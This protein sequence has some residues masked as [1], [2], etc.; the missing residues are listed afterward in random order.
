[1]LERRR[2]FQYPLPTGKPP[3]RPWPTGRPERRPLRSNLIALVASAFLMLVVLLSL[4]APLVAPDDPMAVDVAVQLQPP[5]LA[6]LAGT[7]LFGRD[8]LSRL[9]HGGRLTLSIALLAMVV[10]MLPGVSLGMLAGF[11]EGWPDALISRLTDVLLTIPYLLLALG[12]V[13][14]LGPGPANVALGIG[15][16]GIAGTVRVVRAAVVGVRRRPFVLAARA[17]GCTNRRTLLRHI[18]PN[19]A[20]PI[21]VVTTLQLGWAILNIAALNFLGVGTRPG[22]PEWGAMLNEG[23]GFIRQAPWIAAAPGTLLTL[24]VLS[25]NLVGDG[26]RDAIDPLLRA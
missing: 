19:V 24:T 9:L 14:L 2:H 11:Y 6:H 1:M 18:L 23:R 5:T 4:A 21:L 8:V 13:A 25:V 26:L 15:L 17:I 22:V 7:D 10:A 12:V 20:G 16:A 3:P